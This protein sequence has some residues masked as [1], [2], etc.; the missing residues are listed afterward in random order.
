MSAAA[1]KGFFTLAA[2]LRRPKRIFYLSRMFA[3]GK[4]RDFFLAT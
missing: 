3:A 4:K 2:S 1:K